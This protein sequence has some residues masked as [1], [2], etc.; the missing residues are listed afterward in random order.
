MPWRSLALYALGTA[1]PC[2]ACFETNA[3][4]KPANVYFLRRLVFRFVFFAVL[5]FA[6]AFFAMLPS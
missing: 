1:G 2:D 5:D 3:A 6:F 4:S